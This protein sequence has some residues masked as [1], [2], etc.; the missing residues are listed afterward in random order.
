MLMP[1]PG[2]GTLTF[3]N[4]NRPDTECRMTFEYAR[5]YMNDALWIEGDEK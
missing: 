1:L 3:Y 5:A 2:G 4:T